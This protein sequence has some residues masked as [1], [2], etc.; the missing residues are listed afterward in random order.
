[1][2]PA[3]LHFFRSGP[4]PCP[5][6]PGREERKL[7]VR[8]SGPDAPETN[9]LL[10]GAGFR[11][12][13]DVAYRPVCP[14]CS[15]CVPVRIPID[16]F[17]PDRTQRRIL[18]R[19]ADLSLREAPAIATAE[20]FMLFTRYEGARHG[21]SDMARMT[22]GDY[23][24]MVEEGRVDTVVVEA[25]ASSGRL[26]GAML[27]DR[28]G[29]GFSA[30]YAFFDPAL[31]RRSLGTFLILDLARRAALGGLPHL[32][33][34]YWIAGSRKMAYKVRFRPLEALLDG[35]W[36]DLEPITVDAMDAAPAD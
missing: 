12:S 15:A 32:Y 20:Q 19:N 34:G 17:E 8:L 18:A 14:A 35:G 5:Y 23:T 2:E 36:R 27:A 30:V 13:H 29:D 4:M 31:G 28:L 26:V 1:M 16:R 25:R 6:L 10:T 21:D 3:L 22:A 9:T 24:A 11:R 33:L 7:F